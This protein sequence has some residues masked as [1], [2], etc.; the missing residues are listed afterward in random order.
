M[1]EILKDP[2]LFFMALSIVIACTSMG[3]ALVTAAIFMITV[4]L[5]LFRHNFK[6]LRSRSVTL[7][8]CFVAIVLIYAGFGK[9]T[10]SP[11]SFRM[12]TF[13]FI[14]MISVFVMSYHLRTLNS[15]QI[16]G[17]MKVAFIA[18]L[19]SIIGTTAVSFINPM[20]VRIYGFGDVEDVDFEIANRYRMMGMMGY[21]LAHAFSVVAVGLSILVFRARNKWL[22]IISAILLVLT[23][24]LLFMMT[25]TTALLLAVIGVAIVLANHFSNGRVFVTISLTLAALAVF[26]LAGFATIFLDF[27]SNL[28][29]EITKKLVDLFSFAE[30]GVASGQAGYR[31]ELYMASFKTFLSNPVFGWG[32][33]NGSRQFIG[34]HSYMLD[35][36]AYYGVFALLLFVSWFKEF[37]VLKPLLPNKLRSYYI[38]SFIPVAGLCAMKGYSVC[39]SL[40]FMSLV[41]V[42]LIFLY[43]MNSD[44]T[45]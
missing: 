3:S 2:V 41:V 26:F 35:Y 16:N 20:A 6:P 23:I 33:D 22:K 29:T 4:L 38:F 14:T 17:L 19:F 12:R 44:K 24:R 34:E 18:L 42:Q 39:V 7:Y 15:K 5:I 10:L 13:S 37:F 27:S 32:S 9:G 11:A 40:P 43:L 31:Q 36:L 30:S 1:K 28:N 45:V 21:S 25:I 8:L